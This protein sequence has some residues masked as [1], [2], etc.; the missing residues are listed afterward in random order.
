MGKLREDDV[1]TRQT[2]S[3]GDKMKLY[4]RHWAETLHEVGAKYPKTMCW[5]GNCTRSYTE[6]NPSTV[7]P[8]DFS[9]KSPWDYVRVC[10][11]TGS[12]YR[13]KSLLCSWNSTHKSTTCK[14]MFTHRPDCSF[15]SSMR[16]VSFR[17][18]TSEVFFCLLKTLRVLCK[19]WNRERWN[20]HFP[21]TG[22]TQIGK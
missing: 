12:F 16:H 10:R 18:Q 21:K 19:Q 1:W 3:G 8:C 11:E 4:G 15:H 5:W 22:L 7:L 13:S 2:D 14:D 9:S 6:Q 17:L 20:V